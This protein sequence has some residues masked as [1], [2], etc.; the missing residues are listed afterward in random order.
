MKFDIGETVI[1]SIEIRDDASVLKAPA[2]SMNILIDQTSPVGKNV[3]ASTTMVNDSTGKYHYDYD[4][5][6]AS[7]GTYEAKYTATDGARITIEKD[8]FIL[9]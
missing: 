5:S 9:E 6:D 3:I 2:T 4:S 8:T 7:E 1:L